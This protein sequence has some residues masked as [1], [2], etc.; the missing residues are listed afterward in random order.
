MVI[1]S[2]GIWTKEYDAIPWSN[3]ACIEKYNPI[4]IPGFQNVEYDISV[5][6]IKLHDP[7]AVLAKASPIGK[8][9]LWIALK[10]NQPYHITLIDLDTPVHE[11]ITFAHQFM[12]K[13]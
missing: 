5:M 12:D 10:C 8:R 11:I 7:E 1:N 9:Y 6:G 4:N 13:L 3:I 2:Q